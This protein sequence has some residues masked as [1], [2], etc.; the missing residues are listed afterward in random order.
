MPE[1]RCE[2][3]QNDFGLPSLLTSLRALIRDARQHVFRSEDVI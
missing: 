1:K 3:V 2:R